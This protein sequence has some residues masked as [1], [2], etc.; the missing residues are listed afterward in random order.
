[1][2]IKLRS[3]PIAGIL[4]LYKLPY[5]LAGI[6]LQFLNTEN[7]LEYFI[8]LSGEASPTI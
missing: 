5:Q 3:K 8:L 4:I 6:K 2:G 1:V 7:R